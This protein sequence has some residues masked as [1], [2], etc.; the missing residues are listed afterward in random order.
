VSDSPLSCP[1]GGT[2]QPFTLAKLD[3]MPRESVVDFGAGNWGEGDYDLMAAGDEGGFRV[4]LDVCVDEVNETVV[5]KR[6]LYQ[7]YPEQKNYV[8][9]VDDALTEPQE[10]AFQTFRIPKSFVSDAGLKEAVFG[11]PQNLKLVVKYSKGYGFRVD[12]WKDGDMNFA[13]AVNG[14][15]QDGALNVGS[16]SL[17]V[18]D[19]QQGDPFQGGPCGNGEF[20]GTASFMLGTA[21]F[22]LESCLFQDTGHTTGYKIKKLTIQDSNPVLKQEQREAF[23][24][25]ND[26]LE[27]VLKYKWDHH[28]ACD[29]FVLK[30]PH[31]TYSATTSAM[32]GCGQILDGA[33]ERGVEDP[34]KTTL[35]RIKYGTQ[36]VIEGELDCVHFHFR[37]GEPAP[38]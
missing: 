35:Y 29:S 32:A 14:Y 27:T 36:S 8:L 16:S 3:K 10:V 37:C 12:G 22:D 28:N 17:I 2:T 6:F 21:K 1:G 30:L 24:S 33:P 9:I 20:I 31:A 4:R 19:F 38:E 26:E 34:R 7:M 25:E 18:G 11:E 5:L 15:D 13:T 23:T